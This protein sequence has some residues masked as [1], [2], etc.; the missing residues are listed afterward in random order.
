MLDTPGARYGAEGAAGIINI[1]LKE[2]VELGLTGS[3]SFAAGTRGQYTAGGRGTLQRGP[4]VF[5]GGLDARWSDSRNAD[6]ILRQNLLANP[7]TFLQQDAQW[8]RSSRNGGVNLDLR[9]ELEEVTTLHPF[10]WQPQRQR[11]GRAHRDDSAG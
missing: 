1:V 2:G 5:N 8:D 6:F 10:Q 7:V 4:L 11:P 9:Y 3:L